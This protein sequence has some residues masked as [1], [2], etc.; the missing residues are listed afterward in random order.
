MAQGVITASNDSVRD[1]I[2][3]YF[4][5]CRNDQKP[6]RDSWVTSYKQ[7]RGILDVDTSRDAFRWRSKLFIPATARA[8][9]GLL[10]KMMLNLFAPD[11]FFGVSPRE[12]MDVD[13]AKTQEAYLSYQ[14][15][16]SNFIH[17]AYWFLKQLDIYGTSLGKVV[18]RKN[19]GTETTQ[20]VITDEQGRPQVKDIQSEVTL[21]DQP[22]FE[23]LDIFDLYWSSRATSLSDTWI[24]QRTEKT[25]GE[26]RRSGVYENLDELESLINQRRESGEYEAQVRNYARGIQAAYSG[27]EG[28]DRT[29]ELLEYWNRDRSKTA[30]I[31][32][33]LVVTRPLRDNPV[34]PKYDPYVLS[35]L[36][37]NPFEFEG[38]GVP[39]KC[40][41][42]Q[43]QINTEVNQRLDNRNLRQNVQFK[44]RKGAGINTRNLQSKPGAIW[45]MD[46]MASLEIVNIPDISSGFSFQEEAHLQQQCEEITGVTR[47]ATGSGSS[48]GEKTATEASILKNAGSDAFAL[49]L[50]LI[51]ESFIKP[52]IRKFIYLNSRFMEQET[53]VRITGDAGGYNFIKVTPGDIQKTDFDLIAHG[54][55]E[56]T[57]KNLKV[58]QMLQFMQIIA[59][60]PSMVPFRTELTRRIWETWGNK[61]FDSIL[62]S[63]TLPQNQPAPALAGM[64]ASQMPPQGAGGM[65]VNPTGMRASSPME[66]LVPAMMGG[67]G[68]AQS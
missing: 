47:Y 48:G 66:G 43:A 63:A 44:V 37:P 12:P 1:L 19:T 53:S 62:R 17:R 5:G 52:V 46:D 35:T 49:H 58:Q 51:A 11:P 3:K 7:Y 4:T 28:D 61:D 40:R 10:P 16:E 41:D 56:I 64:G 24:V 54:A 25:I 42:L 13:Q 30:T 20:I 31:A 39:E 34:G 33:Q 27:E 2:L 15:S 59:Q 68:N 67:G 55:N 22:V 36:F 26:M 9:D 65:P 60:D 14:F 8:V 29:V 45:L 57:D 50:L 21:M 38:T 6:L 23:P 18:W 32:G